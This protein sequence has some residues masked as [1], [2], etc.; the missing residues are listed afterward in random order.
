ME[1]KTQDFERIITMD[2]PWCLTNTSGH[3]P[4]KDLLELPRNSNDEIMVQVESTTPSKARR[5]IRRLQVSNDG[6]R[7]SRSIWASKQV[8]TN[9]LPGTSAGPKADKAMP[10]RMSSTLSSSSWGNLDTTTFHVEQMTRETSLALTHENNLQER[11]AR[12]SSWALL[13]LGSEDG[14][15]DDIASLGRDNG[16][17]S[18]AVNSSH[19]KSSWAGLDVYG[20]INLYGHQ[21]QPQDVTGCSDDTCSVLPTDTTASDIDEDDGDESKDLSEGPTGRRLWFEFYLDAISASG[22]E[23]EAWALDDDE[24]SSAKGGDESES[25]S[26]EDEER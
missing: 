2:L 12:K 16:E 9:G 14:F 19:S 1:A 17:F 24:S 15:G 11:L 3:L 26:D 7:L 25:E 20:E 13:D 5:R 6:K 10:R 22:A 18:F 21:L 8:A 4:A 23:R